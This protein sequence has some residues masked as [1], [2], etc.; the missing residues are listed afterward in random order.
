M[1]DGSVLPS[2]RGVNGDTGSG[3]RYTKTNPLLSKKTLPRLCCS[4]HP[5]MFAFCSEPGMNASSGSPPSDSSGA[6]GTAH[7]NC[8]DKIVL[9][10]Y[11]A[12]AASLGTGTYPQPALIAF[13]SRC[14]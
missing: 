6:I 9:T 12:G 3:H 10:T 4:Q 14:L 7:R 8:R 2:A 5:T 1:G 13:C 11:L